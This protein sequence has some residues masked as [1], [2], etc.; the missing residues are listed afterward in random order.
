MEEPTTF[1]QRMIYK[2]TRVEAKRL[3][4]LQKL[5]ENIKKDYEL[6]LKTK[7]VRLERSLKIFADE[8]KQVN[9]LVRDYNLLVPMHRQLFYWDSQSEIQTIREEILG[10]EE[11]TNQKKENSSQEFIKQQQQEQSTTD[12]ISVVSQ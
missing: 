6:K 2:I 1:Y 4:D 12:P 5:R 10:V 8:I 9:E 7:D 11:T 3:A